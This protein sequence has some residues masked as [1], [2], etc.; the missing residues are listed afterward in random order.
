MT[1]VDC[2]PPHILGSRFGRSGGIQGLKAQNFK[3]FS[4]L[5]GVQTRADQ[6]T[7]EI[8]DDSSHYKVGTVVAYTSV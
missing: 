7:Y 2:D 4:D 3:N 6:Q 8:T 5:N 1:G